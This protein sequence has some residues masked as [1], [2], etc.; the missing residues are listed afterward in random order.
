[1]TT[2]HLSAVARTV[3]DE[4][5]VLLC[6]SCCEQGSEEMS[7]GARRTVRITVTLRFESNSVPVWSACTTMVKTREFQYFSGNA[8]ADGCSPV[9]G[10]YNCVLIHHHGSGE[11]L[12]LPHHHL[13]RGYARPHNRI[14]RL[15]ALFLPCELETPGGVRVSFF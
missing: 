1:M 10:S 11:L 5:C 6:V 4:W 9:S 3:P 12:H 8:P 14:S 13:R 15:F 2:M 7:D